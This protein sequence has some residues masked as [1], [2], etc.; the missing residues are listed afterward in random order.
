MTAF[1]G[2]QK[3]T[4]NPEDIYNPFKTAVKSK[5]VGGKNIKKEKSQKYGN[6][7]TYAIEK[8]A[9]ICFFSLSL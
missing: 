8:N 5:A 1:V 7:K 3:P 2:E 6:K 4:V 9:G